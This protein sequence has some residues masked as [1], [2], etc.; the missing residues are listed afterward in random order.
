MFIRFFHGTINYEY[1]YLATKFPIERI[2]FKGYTF[3]VNNV[4]CDYINNCCKKSCFNLYAIKYTY[5][6]DYNIMLLL[7]P[8]AINNC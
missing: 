2:T 4:T 3:D 6:V 7:Q 1:V 5:S 8:V